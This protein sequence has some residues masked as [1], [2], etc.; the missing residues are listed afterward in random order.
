MEKTK[1]VVDEQIKYI[2]TLLMYTLHKAMLENDK[3]WFYKTEEDPEYLF[4][5]TNVCSVLNLNK[6][7][8]RKIF[9]NKTFKTNVQDIF[10]DK[11]EAVISPNTKHGS[12][13]MYTNHG[14]RCNQCK[15]T[16]NMYRKRL[17]IK[18]KN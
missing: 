8:I 5:F 2:K 14:C 11:K 7:N 12:I 18:N 10:A 17:Y 16:G 9:S 15:A 4:S 1:E 13:S 6:D 3:E